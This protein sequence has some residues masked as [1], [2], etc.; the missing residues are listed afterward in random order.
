MSFTGVVLCGGSS[1]RMGRD[2][3]VL[4]VDGVAMA[5]RVSRALAAAGAQDV[6]A[7]GGDLAGLRALGLD[8]RPDGW[9]GEGPL[10]AT[11]TAL[12]L[13]SAERVLV[14]SC[15]LL[16]PEASAL[17]AT[18]DALAAHPGAVGAVPVWDG[19][20][21]VTHAAWDRR[22]RPALLRAFTAGERSLRR[23]AAD[24]IVVE[25][26]GLDPAALADADIPADLP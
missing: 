7:L 12:E 13:A 3:A 15:D 9:P 16:R 26:R 21:Q 14:A 24:L 18:M 22:A 20:R 25:V 11:I 1:R 5:A 4:E 6:I 17:G 23:A 8:A 2:K 19:R 10:G